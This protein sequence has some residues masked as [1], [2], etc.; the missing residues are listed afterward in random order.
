MS[1]SQWPPTLNKTGPKPCILTAWKCYGGVIGAMKKCTSH[2]EVSTWQNHNNNWNGKSK[3]EKETP[4]QRFL[5]NVTTRLCHWRCAWRGLCGL[6]ECW[7]KRHCQRSWPSCAAQSNS[8]A[9]VW[10][11]VFVGTYMCVCVLACAMVC[12]GLP[13][14][15]CMY[16]QRKI[17]VCILC[18]MHVSST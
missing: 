5:F 15:V 17:C 13:M 18:S 1:L 14:F 2:N 6:G 9:T 4:S 10:N 7:W 12:A 3:R 16:M 11:F 8:S